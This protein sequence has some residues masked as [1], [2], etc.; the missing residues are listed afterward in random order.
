MEVCASI[1]TGTVERDLL[2]DV[3]SSDDSG[4][5]GTATSE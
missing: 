4:D 2:V 5:A 1:L 3:S